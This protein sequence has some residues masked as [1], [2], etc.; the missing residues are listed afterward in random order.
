MNENKNIAHS[1]KYGCKTG[2]IESGLVDSVR[3]VLS[4]CLSC[5][6]SVPISGIS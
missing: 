2:L 3:V 6:I 5:M 1:P 4:V